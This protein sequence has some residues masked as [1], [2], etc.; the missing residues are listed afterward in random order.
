MN[1]PFSGH[2]RN[3]PCHSL[4]VKRGWVEVEVEGKGKG[5]DVR[6]SGRWSRRCCR[7]NSPVH[8]RGAK[9]EVR[10]E[11]ERREGKEVGDEGVPG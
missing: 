3:C 11:E 5:K 10:K 8:A 7:N 9:C 2:A 1:I 6:G 4:S